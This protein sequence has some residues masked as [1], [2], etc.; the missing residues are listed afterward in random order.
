MT[1]L[2][3]GSFA[4]VC[5]IV[6][7]FNKIYGKYNALNAFFA[8]GVGFLIYASI[9][10]ITHY[11]ADFAVQLVYQI[12]F[13]LMSALSGLFMLYAL[14]GALPFT[15][16]YV[17][18]NDNNVIDTGVYALCRH[19][20]V[21]GFFFMYFFAF[22]ASGRFIVLIACLVWT[23]L[24]I[25]H[26]WLQDIIFFPK[27]LK[28]YPEYQKSTPFLLFNSQSIQRCTSTFRK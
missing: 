19:P 6:F 24:D 22:L 5:L 26:V 28:G 13:A 18:V 21:W 17:E 7:D 15:K 11:P 1:T 25:I 4:F 8:I 27:M 20:G 12:L 2:V 3:I 14:F 16:T 10:L 9:T 23:G